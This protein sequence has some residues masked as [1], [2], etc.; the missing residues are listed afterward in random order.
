MGS[1]AAD[2]ELLA[3]NWRTAIGAAERDGDCADR[4]RAD[5]DWKN[6]DFTWRYRN[7]LSLERT[8]SI[9]AVHL[10]PYI[11]AEPYYESQYHKWSTTALYAGCYIPLGRYVQFS[12]YYEH[13]NNTGK[14]PNQ[15]ANEIGLALYL[16]FSLEKK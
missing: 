8:F 2:G 3:G 6:G 14:K 10:I 16:Y 5:L 15:Q 9:D 1:G 4:N 12:S 13:E 7:K 11:A